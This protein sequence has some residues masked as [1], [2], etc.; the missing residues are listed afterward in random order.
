M[1][2]RIK[3]LIT[4][5]LFCFLAIFA[6][7]F[8]WQVIDRDNLLALASGQYNVSLEIPA[9]RGKIFSSD[10]YPLVLNQ[11]I[12]N[13]FVNPQELNIFPSDLFEMI[14]S[15]VKKEQFSE[16]A[17]ANKLSLM[18]RHK[19]LRW[20]SLVKD[21]SEEDKQEIEKLK[22]NGLGFEEKEKRFYPESSMSAHLLGFVGE[23]EKGN[24]KGYFGLEGYYDNEIKGKSGGRFF[25]Q[26]ALGR[27]VPLVAESLEKPIQGRNLVLNIDRPVQFLVEKHLKDAIKKYSAASGLVVIMDP[28]NGGVLSMASFPSYDPSLYYLY[29]QQLYRNPVVSSSF[30]PGSIFKLIVMAAAVDSGVIKKDD[31]CSVCDGPKKIGEYTIKTWNEKYYPSS[32][33]TDII[34]HSDNVGM[35]YVGQKLGVEKL[36]DYLKRFGFGERTGIDLQG[37][38]SPEL[39]EKMEWR[40]IDLATVSFGQ[41]IAATPIQILDAVSSIANNGE[42]YQPQVVDKIF[43]GPQV[44][45]IKPVRKRNPIS[46]NTARIITR[47]MV[48]AVEKGEAKWAKPK[49]YMIAGKTGTAQIPIAGHYDPEKTVASFVGFAPADN[50]AFAML[51]ALKE[52]KTSPWGSETAAPLWFEIAKD[53]FKLWKIPPS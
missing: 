47:M 34:V 32:L 2:R 25:E 14:K 53:I 5:F 22:I 27:P 49:D 6:K 43:D 50:P 1:E 33:M 38:V 36:Y 39:R 9:P 35:V 21:L 8:Y 13:L 15:L 46:S 23:D 3:L 37:E 26:D 31:V 52:P 40:E 48:E 7:L 24:K 45:N 12:Y 18:L 41:G 30:E 28:K 51:V 44:V 10:N 16:L 29:D 11:K 4:F 42:L 20:I 19:N 17:M